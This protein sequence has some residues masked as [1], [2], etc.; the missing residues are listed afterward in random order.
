MKLILLPREEEESA[1]F[2]VVQLGYPNRTSQN[3]AEIILAVLWPA[4]SALDL[5]HIRAIQGL[6]AV[7][8]PVVGVEDT[9]FDDGVGDAVEIVRSGL[10]GE[11]FDA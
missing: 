10:C 2:A 6:V 3:S 8:E 9:V 5:R 4:E 11:A 1:V 7:V